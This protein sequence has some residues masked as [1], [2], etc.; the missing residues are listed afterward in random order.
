MD[1]ARDVLMHVCAGFS[2]VHDRLF[3]QLPIRPRFTESFGP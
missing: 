3:K 2:A 1:S